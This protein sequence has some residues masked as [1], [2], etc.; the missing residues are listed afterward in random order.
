MSNKIDK[1]AEAI[2]VMSVGPLTQ[3]VKQQAA[4]IAE[5][6]ADLEASRNVNVKVI[7]EELRNARAAD[8]TWFL[9]IVDAEGLADLPSDEEAALRMLVRLAG[10]GGAP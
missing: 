2:A 10:R 1:R 3:A 5:L 7:C 6:E 4:R 9:T 8:R